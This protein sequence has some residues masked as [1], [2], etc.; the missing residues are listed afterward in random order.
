MAPADDEPEPSTSM[1][2][3]PHDTSPPRV[4]WTHHQH[5]ADYVR[6]MIEEGEDLA[7]GEDGADPLITEVFSPMFHTSIFKFTLN[8]SCFPAQFI[9][10][11]SFRPCKRS[12]LLTTLKAWQSY[13]T[14]KQF[15]NWKWLS[16]VLHVID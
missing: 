10:P 5:A 13:F 8:S 12:V 2:T 11:F 14:Q 1:S 16:W 3:E 6:L 7:L 9:T 15:N 4:L